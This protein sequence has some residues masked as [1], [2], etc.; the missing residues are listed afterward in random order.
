M[1]MTVI[2]S[3]P[4]A[5]EEL[6]MMSLNALIM[7]AQK[8]GE[9]R[10]LHIDVQEHDGV[11][12]ARARVEIME[13]EP[14]SED[15]K[16][17]GESGSGGDREGRAPGGDNSGYYYYSQNRDLGSRQQLFP[18]MA[19]DVFPEPD[20]PNPDA[21]SEEYIE[22]ARNDAAQSEAEDKDWYLA[23][24]GLQNPFPPE[25]DSGGI[26]R[27]ADDIMVTGGTDVADDAYLVA[28][29]GA[30]G[31]YDAG[32]DLETDWDEIREARRRRS[33]SLDI[34]AAPAPQI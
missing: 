13:F 4:N 25:E 16:T 10:V 19:D 1:R 5:S 29:R 31:T 15:E 11:F 20:L 23:E 14:E 32:A 24:A 21:V 6:A 33:R 26:M 7:F 17:Q 28:A 12:I 22:I 8:D 9:V 27:Q 3:A 18:D 30:E 2:E 34:P